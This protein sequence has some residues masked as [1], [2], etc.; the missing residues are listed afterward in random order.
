MFWIQPKYRRGS[1]LRNHPLS[2][3]RQFRKQT[4]E[5]WHAEC[6]ADEIRNLQIATRSLEFSEGFRAGRSV[7]RVENVLADKLDDAKSGAAA[8][9]AD[10]GA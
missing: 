7:G 4:P 3:D 1:R 2:D 5:A 6:L 8:V 9:A 10:S